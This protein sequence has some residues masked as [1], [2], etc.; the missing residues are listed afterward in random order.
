MY[1]LGC[2]TIYYGEVRDETDLELM[3]MPLVLNCF[4]FNFFFFF[5]LI[6]A[7]L[8]AVNS[9]R[10]EGTVI[11]KTLLRIIIF[12]FLKYWSESVI[13]TQTNV[14]KQGLSGEEVFSL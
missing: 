12:L 3:G 5:L 2:L 14:S 1:A 11:G 9:K 4:G 8:Y 10:G 6:M 7:A 13:S